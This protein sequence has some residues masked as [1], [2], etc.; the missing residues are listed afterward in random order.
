MAKKKVEQLHVYL[1]AEELKA[2]KKM[3]KGFNL[4]LSAWAKLKLLGRI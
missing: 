1:S 2:I 4:S 3:A